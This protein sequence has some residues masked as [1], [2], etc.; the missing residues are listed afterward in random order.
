VGVVFIIFFFGSVVGIVIVFCGGC[1]GVLGI[2]GFVVLVCCGWLG[3]GGG[4]DAFEKTVEKKVLEASLTVKTWSP[5]TG[6]V[7]AEV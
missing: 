3:G 2:F 5:S 7:R 4:S 1:F 6:V